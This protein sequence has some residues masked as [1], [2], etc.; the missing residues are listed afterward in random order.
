MCFDRLS[1]SGPFCG[2]PPSPLILSLS[3]DASATPRG[4]PLQT[5][6]RAI[7]SCL[8]SALSVGT[9]LFDVTLSQIRIGAAM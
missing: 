1:T 4:T 9:K 8:S 3:K 6:S 7:R 2:L 5:P